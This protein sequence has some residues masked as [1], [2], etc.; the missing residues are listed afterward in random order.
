MNIPTE[1]LRKSLGASADVARL[2]FESRTT[3]KSRTI[4]EA[5]G[6]L[7]DSSEGAVYVY[8]GQ[9]GAVLYV[10][11]TSRNVKARLHDQ[12]SP[13]KEKPWWSQW[14]TMRFVQLPDEMD[15]LILEFMLI[16][17]YSPLHNEKPK[18]KNIN[19][20]LPA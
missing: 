10:G 4:F 11:Q 15:R 20:L 9:G 7:G 16:L 1:T 8:Y 5:K 18:A 2:W 14:E 17:A 3:P 6:Q 13:H 19:E 12:T